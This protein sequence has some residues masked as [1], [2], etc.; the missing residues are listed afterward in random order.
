MPL[1]IK[2]YHAVADVEHSGRPREDTRADDE[3][4]DHRPM[5]ATG[6][7]SLSTS[8]PV[9]SPLAPQRPCAGSDSSRREGADA[10]EWWRSARGTRREA[11]VAAACRLLEEEGRR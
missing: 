10:G 8:A 3:D 9:S 6:V 1:Q 7:S 11:E 5:L 2:L 4:A